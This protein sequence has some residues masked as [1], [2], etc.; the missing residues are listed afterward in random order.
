MK[1]AMKPTMKPLSKTEISYSDYETGHETGAMKPAPSKE[2]LP[3]P[4]RVGDNDAA[5]LLR[6]SVAKEHSICRVDFWVLLY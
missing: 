1:L 6:A 4:F 2:T 5:G 3:Y